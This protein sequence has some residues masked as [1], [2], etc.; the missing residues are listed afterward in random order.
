M[1]FMLLFQTYR[2]A[3]LSSRAGYILSPSVISYIQE[4]VIPLQ[5]CVDAQ[6]VHGAPDFRVRRGHRGCFLR[7]TAAGIGIAS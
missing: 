3:T 2:I 1:V 6:I 4:F 5:I 7:S